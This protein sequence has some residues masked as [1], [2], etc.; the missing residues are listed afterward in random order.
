MYGSRLLWHMNKLQI[1]IQGPIGV[2]V[3]PNT[4]VMNINVK[5]VLLT[6]VKSATEKVQLTILDTEVA[7]QFLIITG[8]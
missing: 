6:S 1:N 2:A 5:D 8:L 4:W 7:E 3:F